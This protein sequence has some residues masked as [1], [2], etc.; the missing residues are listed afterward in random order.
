M[1][2]NKALQLVY[3][4]RQVAINLISDGATI[5]K[6]AR[7]MVSILRQIT[8]SGKPQEI[9]DHAHL[10]K[11]MRVLSD[12]RPIAFAGYLIIGLTFGVAG[13]W[14]SV[15]KIDK[16]IFASGNV[17]I[18]TNHKTVQHLEGGIIR[19][20]LVKEGEHVTE[21]QVLFRLQKVQAEA[22]S[23]M[24]ENQLDSALALEARLIAERDH[25]A[26]I[27]WPQQLINRIDNSV[28]AGLVIDQQKQFL[29][30]Q[31]SLSD[32]V[33]VLQARIEELQKQI[34]G[35]QIEKDSTEKQVGYINQELIGLRDLGAKKLVPMT[36]VY[37]MERERTRLEGVIG[38]SE[39]EAA[40]AQS[41]IGETK[42]QMQQL[43]QK[44]QE[45]VNANLLEA[46]QKIADLKERA[47]VAGDVLNRN[48]IRAPRTGTVQNLKVFTIGQVIRPGEPLLDVVPDNEPL[49]VEAQFSPMDIDSVHAGMRAEIRFPAFHSRT[50]PVMFG[51]LKTVSHDRLINELTHQYYYRGVIS[52]AR[53]DMPE[54]YRSRLRPGMPAEVIIST[55]TSTVMNHLV[56]PLSSSLRK[57]MREP[58][59]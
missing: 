30:R 38:Q 16:A 39:A 49:V 26:K 59:D 15:A 56:S 1:I 35:I 24:I 32:Q 2:K 5:R 11:E 55:G 50:I 42:L 22:S 34:D 52:L 48:D 14:P 57:A 19:E 58:N 9:I 41:S 46:R 12:W 18:D 29:E 33:K 25:A 37:A 13:V 10:Q 3:S 7:R 36:R 4:L 6:K 31:A 23:E 40:K 21:G 53:A 45:E 20:I 51:V 43:Q 47:A 27:A 44:F 17:D 28:V 8:A 54:E